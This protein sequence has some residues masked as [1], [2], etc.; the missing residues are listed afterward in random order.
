MKLARSKQPK[1]QRSKNIRKPQYRS[2]SRSSHEIS[3]LENAHKT[4][5]KSHHCEVWVI[6]LVYLLATQLLPMVKHRTTLINPCLQ[7]VNTK[8]KH[9]IGESVRGERSL[10]E[11]ARVILTYQELDKRRSLI[12]QRARLSSFRKALGIKLPIWARGARARTE[13]LRQRPQRHT[14]DPDRCALHS[15]QW[16]LLL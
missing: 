5:K 15:R 6:A 3:V 4:L 11:R 7:N 16:C 14:K 9:T 12:Y 13:S 2:S 1:N 10:W 8:T